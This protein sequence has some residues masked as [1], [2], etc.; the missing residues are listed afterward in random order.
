MLSKIKKNL[1]FYTELKMTRIFRII[2]VTILVLIT[3]YSCNDSLKKKSNQITVHN[4]FNKLFEEYRKQSKDSLKYRASK[5]LVENI[6][7]HGHYEEKKEFE[8][9]FDS[10][11]NYPFDN[12]RSTYLL[13]LL[14]SVHQKSIKT[15]NSYVPDAETIN[16]N[17]LIKYIDFTFEVWRKIPLNKRASFE[18][19]C[20][21][22][23]PYK[24]ANEPFNLES[25]KRL[26]SQYKW[27]MT[28][29]EKGKSLKFVVDS[30]TSSFEYEILA[31]IYKHYPVPLSLDQIEKTRRGNCD[32][33]VMYFVNVFRSLG[34]ISSKDYIPHWG[35]HYSLGHSWLYVKYGEEEYACNIGGKINLKEKFKINSIIPK[36]YRAAYKYEGDNL[37]S[38]TGK[39]IS[40]Q[41]FETVDFT[42]KN[43]FQSKLDNAKLCV[44]D[45][46]RDWFVVDNG[47]LGEKGIK[48]I[49]VGIDGEILFAAM[50]ES[51][52]GLAPINYPFYFN[53]K[54]KEIVYL[55][56]NKSSLKTIILTRKYGLTSPREKFKL[57]RIKSLNGGVF[58]G[59]NN[60]N[61]NNS[62]ELFRV[63]N[64]NST[65][66]KKIALNNNQKFKYIRFNSKGKKTFLAK[67]HFFDKNEK[68][69]NGKVFSDNLSIDSL[70]T[71][72]FDNNQLTFTGGIDFKLGLK[73]TQPQV[74]GSIKFQARNDDNHINIG[75]KYELFYWDK[76]WISM[77][78]K[79]AND[80]VLFYK[81]YQNALLRLKN[82]TKGIEEH[83]FIW[84][85][86]GKQ[87]WLGFDNFP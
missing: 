81:V 28:Y 31:D 10:I 1:F 40:N 46:K 52:T 60:R 17:D 61:F 69:L 23:L 19:F 66:E 80:T 27:V 78:E 38:L 24:V 30:L 86:N 15:K 68:R 62:K 59:S 53:K 73:L 72:A 13:K 5:F 47:I 70:G 74:I 3:N 33:S 48:F 50:S 64:L 9:V 55:R 75:E 2:S 21:Y 43:E 56:P 26:N 57:N 41:Y 77:G 39:D 11:L 16:I 58:E 85:E 84:G 35:N 54:N 6:A 83:V 71:N 20:Q 79:I 32:D 4:K 67:L 12:E 18:D 14:T 29:L 76:E 44:F 25:R 7:Y 37:F 36:I 42:V 63:S 82:N 22:I 51:R 87:K 49:N 65:H 8:S 45:S 34:F